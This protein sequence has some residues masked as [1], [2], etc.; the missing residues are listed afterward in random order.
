MQEIMPFMWMAS[1]FQESFENKQRQTWPNKK[2]TL[3]D[4]NCE[5][6]QEK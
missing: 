5:N 6:I 3:P 4:K 1:L 2:E